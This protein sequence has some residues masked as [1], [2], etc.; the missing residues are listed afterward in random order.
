MEIVALSLL[1]S[2]WQ[3]CFLVRIVQQ[4]ICANPQSEN[5]TFTQTAYLK[6]CYIV[7]EELRSKWK[8][9]EKLC[10]K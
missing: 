7:K 8:R 3:W 10:D 6:S 9:D 4:Q 1:S 2:Y 5:S